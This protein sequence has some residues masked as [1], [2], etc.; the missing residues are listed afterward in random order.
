VF[1]LLTAAVLVSVIWLYVQRVPRI[2]LAARVPASSIGY[3]EINDWPKLIDEISA[4]E[5]WANLAPVYGIWDK[6]QYFG[7][8]GWLV[9]TTGIGTGEI[10]VFSRAQVAIVVTSLEV[11]GDEVKPRL[12]L[13]LETHSREG[14]L[15]GVIG[16]RLPQ[17]A[18]RVFGQAVPELS[19]Y[20][21]VPITLFRGASDNRIMASAQIGSE[22]IIANHTEAME[23]CVDARLGRVATLADNSYLQNARTI[24]A[25]GGPL[26]GF[27]SAD[28]ATRL[29]RFTAHVIGGR[30]FG[31]GPLTE[32]LQSFAADFSAQASNGLAYGMTFEQGQAVDRYAWLCHPQMVD[33]L[34]NAIQVKKDEL[35]LPRIAPAS[36]R[37]MTIIAVEEP[38]QSFEAVEAVISSRLG[39]AQSFIFRRFMLGARE[40]LF[41]LKANETASSAFG[42]ELASIGFGSSADERLWLLAVKD[43]TQLEQLATRLRTQDKAKITRETHAGV[44]VLVS[45]DERRGAAAFLG[46]FLALGSRA[47]LIRFIATSKDGMAFADSPQFISA[48]KPA[49]PAPIVGFSSVRDETATMMETLARELPRGRARAEPEA[50]LGRLP[51]SSN[52][53]SLGERD[54]LYEAHSP[55]GRIPF[56][57]SLFSEAQGSGVATEERPVK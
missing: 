15:R 53:I 28:G 23:A 19:Q 17:I 16:R 2:D 24:V 40:V 52:T 1:R 7:K 12:A 50:A 5:A 11:R 43:R 9:R 25:N 8:A 33:Q 4:S 29:A 6:W 37:E 36:V 39:A 49:R 18:R 51:L 31:D 22:W 26:F 55:F 30:I 20:A 27:V 34:R 35:R 13:V 32:G 21:G 47:P 46:D 14:Q 56:I 48:R 44:E 57:V 54:I 3:L 38:S 42:D 45:S 41:G 10:I